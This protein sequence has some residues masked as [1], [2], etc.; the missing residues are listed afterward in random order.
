MFWRP[1]V[2]TCGWHGQIQLGREIPTGQATRGSNDPI[3]VAQAGLEPEPRAVWADWLNQTNKAIGHVG[4]ETRAT[5]SYLRHRLKPD[6]LPDAGCAGIDTLNI[7]VGLCLLAPRLWNVIIIA[8]AHDDR[9][10]LANHLAG[11]LHAK[12]CKASPVPAKFLPID[13]DRRIVINCLEV[14]QDALPGPVKGDSHGAA[15]PDGGEKISIANSR[16][17][18]FRAEW[19]ENAIR[20]IALQQ[21]SFQAAVTGIDLELPLSIQ[22][23]PG[24]AHTLWSWIFRAR[25]RHR[26]S[27]FLFKWR[28]GCALHVHGRL[29]VPSGWTSAGGMFAA[30]A[31]TSRNSYAWQRPVSSIKRTSSRP[32]CRSTGR[33]W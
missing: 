7:I 30:V 26:T 21:P 20:E 29:D 33:I 12:R 2:T 24:W 32:S 6:R 31:A 9:D 1:E 5:Q 25:N 17:W 15:I 16:Q 22:A 4:R 18:G 27:F 23:E 28:P 19:N 11:Q 13:P 8:R 14:E 3:T 10:L